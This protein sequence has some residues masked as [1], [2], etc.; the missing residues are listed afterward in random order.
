MDTQKLMNII[1]MFRFFLINN[2][3]NINII[4]PDLWTLI[5]SSRFQ[6]SKYQMPSVMLLWRRF[7]D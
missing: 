7:S 2:K 4:K 3:Y 1:Q 6:K 5:E